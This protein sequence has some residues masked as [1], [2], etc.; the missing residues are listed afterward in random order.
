MRSCPG[1]GVIYVLI[2]ATTMSR[3]EFG[4]LLKQYLEGKCS[5]EEKELVEHWYGLIQNKDREPLQEAD[6]QTMEPLLWRQ[7]QSRTQAPKVIPM[8]QEKPRPGFSYAWASGIAASIL[9]VLLAGWWFYAN[10]TEETLISFDQP[11]FQK[12]GW[13]FKTNTS[14]K[15]ELITL[16][17]G[18][19]LRL[20]PGSSVRYPSQFAADKR[21]VLLEGEAFFTVQKMPT[22][23][24]LV[25]TGKVV[26]KVLGTSFT[27]K[28]LGAAKQVAVEVVTGKVAV[29]EQGSKAQNKPKEVVL[30]PNEKVVYTT[31]N[32]QFVV[33]IVERPQLIAAEASVPQPVSFQFEDTPLRKVLDRLET[34]YGLSIEIANEK[35]QDCPLTADLSNL[36]LF[37]QLDMIC[38]A[39]KSEYAVQG[40]RIVINGKGCA[41][42]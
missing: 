23:P 30:H 8:P 21:E 1:E 11:Q 2:N 26:T 36:S 4:F 6:L 35:Q 33:G 42:L 24:F 3:K 17:D 14:T 12:A 13:L 16:A 32:Q 27:V 28:M 20:T 34:A 31:E 29:Y 19:T 22:R 40:T 5:P 9:L 41:N 10:R 7:I 39:T 38:A 18:S 37:E 15:S 25:Y